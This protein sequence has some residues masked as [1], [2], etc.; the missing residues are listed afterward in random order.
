MVRLAQ[1]WHSCC[2]S[3]DS[4]QSEISDQQL[5][6]NEA[7]EIPIFVK[8]QYGTSEATIFLQKPYAVP[9]CITLDLLDGK[10]AFVGSVKPGPIQSYNEAVTPDMRLNSGDFITAVNGVEGCA[11]EIAE[12]LRKEIILTIS[13][14]RARQFYIVVNVSEDFHF[15]YDYVSD[16]CSLLIQDV[17]QGPFLQW[18]RTNKNQQVRVYD[19]IVEVNG[20]TGTS[21]KLD[22]AL[23]DTKCLTM[24]ISSPTSWLSL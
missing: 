21:E 14:R 9:A 11:E 17:D 3:Q 12:T 20:V 7:D 13:V 2:D 24:L 10:T 5:R 16:G 8:S 15:D 4:K 18:N 1:W 19:R 22:E 23:N 6:R